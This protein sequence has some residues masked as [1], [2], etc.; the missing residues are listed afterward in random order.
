MGLEKEDLFHVHGV[1][2]DWRNSKRMKVKID[3][4]IRHELKLESD[5]LIISCIAELSSRKNQMFLLRNWR[6]VIKECPSAHLVLIGDGPDSGSIKKFIREH[7][8]N[9]I[10][11]LGFRRDVPP[12]IAASDIVTLVS[13]HEGLPEMPNGSNGCWK[14]HYSFQCTGFEGF[15]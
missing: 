10:H 14:T 7:N 6:S 11:M 12:I 9:N 13:I 1:G 4:D 15:S 8:L 5:S 2:V 3:E